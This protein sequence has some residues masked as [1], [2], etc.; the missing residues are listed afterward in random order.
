MKK[1]SLET[2]DITKVMSFKDEI[3]LSDKEVKQVQHI[4]LDMAKDAISCCERRGVPYVLGG[5]TCLGAIRHEGFIPWDDDMDLNIARSGY[6]D[7][8][9]EIKLSHEDKYWLVY[10]GG[11]VS[12]GFAHGAIQKSGTCMRTI[13]D[14][15]ETH[16]GVSV[17][18]FIIENAPDNPVLRRLHGLLCM[19]FGLCLSCRRYF[20]LRHRILPLLEEGSAAKKSLSVKV[21]IGRL[22]SF[23]KLGTWARWTDRIYSLCKNNKSRYVVIPTGRRHYFKETYERSMFFPAADADFEGMRWKVPADTDT[24]LK[25]LYG[26]DYMTPPPPE[27]RERHIV[28]EFDLGE[29]G[30]ECE[31]GSEKETAE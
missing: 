2:G 19:A 1:F 27:D 8:L 9:D 3:E 7:L 31:K 4:S 5:G 11:D 10:P 25:T 30:V 13:G 28:L 26:P 16:C 21:S 17:D 29:F 22:L 15:D 14:V 6:L 12:A 20:E 24:Y 18:F 23:A